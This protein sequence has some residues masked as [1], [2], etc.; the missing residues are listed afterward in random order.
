M[1]GLSSSVAVPGQYTTPK[2]KRWI[3]KSRSDSTQSGP[4]LQVEESGY[5]EKEESKSSS[6]FL[7]TKMWKFFIPQHCVC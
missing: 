3:F 1:S 5:H 6:P 4:F 2:E 7:E